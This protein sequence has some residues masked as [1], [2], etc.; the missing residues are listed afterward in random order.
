M[1]NV[2]AIDGPSGSGKGTVARIIANKLGYVYVDTGAMY[3]CVTL[4]MLNCG[5]N[6]SDEEKIIELANNIN[7]ELLSDGRVLLDGKDVSKDIRSLK[8]NDNVFLVSRIIKVRE[9]L[10]DLQ[11]E[12]SL[13]NNL[14]MEG[15]DITTV[16]FPNA[17]YKFYLDATLEERAKR[18][19]K[20]NIEKGIECTYG[21][22]LEHFKERDYKD[23]HKSF[24]ALTRTDEQ[25]YIDSTNM[26]IDEVVEKMLSYIKEK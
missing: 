20:E 23:S 7:I 24:G 18:R 2:V 1:Y 12:L 22:V 19:Y 21:E 17:K 9:H 8:V 3:R 26:S 13:K 11:K 15:R 5:L 25:I 4:A 10:V 14:V 6:V 16:V